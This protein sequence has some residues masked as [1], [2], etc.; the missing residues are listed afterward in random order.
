MIEIKLKKKFRKNVLKLNTKLRNKI[1]QRLQV[2][3]ENPHAKE[4]R[5]HK[6]RGKFDGHENLDVTGDLRIII[7]P[8]TNEIIDVVDIGN[9]GYFTINLLFARHRV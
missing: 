7:R 3:V 4:L 2:F 9:H 6:L 8:Q 5:R 1:R